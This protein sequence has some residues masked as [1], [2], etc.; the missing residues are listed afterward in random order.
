M[1]DCN[2]D[3][4]SCNEK[5][6][7]RIEKF[8][9]EDHSKVKKVYAVVSGKGG[10][11]KSMVTSLLSTLTRREGYNV[12]VLDADITGPSMC[13]EFGLTGLTEGSKY[14]ILPM[15]TMT[16]IK[17]VSMNMFLEN[18]SDPVVWRSSLINSAVR[19]FF[20]ETYWGDVDYMYVDMPPG[21]GDVTLT[22]FQSLPIDGIIIVTS[23]QDLVSMIV[24]K[25]VKMAKMM[26]VPIIGIVQ[27]MSYF[28][29]PNCKEKHFIFG[30]NKV[31]E[32]A[33]EFDIKVSASL[34][35]DPKLSEMTDLGLVE[36]YEGNDLD[37][38]IKELTK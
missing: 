34:P 20:T 32:I 16:G 14:G 6:A 22:V 9:V 24:E 27:N 7:S 37:P 25:A 4:S 36:Q 2:H 30:K 21:T 5:C 33:Q 17:V 38:L 13:K 19:Q 28:V 11:G 23:P 1:S 12:A 15:E 35:I 26:N 8:K 29:C 18:P 3:C 31:D 10:V